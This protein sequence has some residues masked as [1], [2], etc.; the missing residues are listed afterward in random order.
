MSAF[1]DVLP[2]PQDDGPRPVVPIRYES[3][4]R[5]TM[6]L[7][8]AIL[9]MNELSARALQLTADVIDLNAANYTAWHFRR[10]CL[11]ELGSDLHGELQ[12]VADIAG[13]NPKNYQI[14]HHR[15]VIA[16]LL[17]DTATTDIGEESKEQ[18]GTSGSSVA[19]IE[20]AYT[21]AVLDE[22]SKNYHAWSHRQWV[23]RHFSRW[24]SELIFVEAMIKKDVRNNSAWN[25]RW[26][27]LHKGNTTTTTTTTTTNTTTTTT[28][29][30]PPSPA[31]TATTSDKTGSND[32]YDVHQELEYAFCA[33]ALAPKN[34]APW[35]YIEGLMRDRNYEDYPEVR[36][37]LVSLADNATSMSSP[38][39]LAC[40]IDVLSATKNEDDLKKAKQ[41]CLELETNL[42]KIRAKY[43][44]YRGAHIL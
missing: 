14:W 22:D 20:L 28:T 37:H 11:R 19:D 26:F 24:E 10:R 32:L 9:Q 40:W 36:E 30:I 42:D 3:N 35:S 16:Q 8:R 15:R 31:T 27:C 12:Y 17:S 38:P 21:A 7:F 25:Q 39:V 43:W 44:A 41:L 4:F 23:V 33:S 2:V 18:S 1:A 13:E 6:D 29:T 5:T 34:Q